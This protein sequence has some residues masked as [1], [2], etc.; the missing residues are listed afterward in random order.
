M[1]GT[2]A[3]ATGPESYQ[4]IEVIPFAGSM[5]AEIQGVDLANLD[6]ATFD[7]LYA[8]WLCHH[9]VVMRDQKITPDQQI[10]F[11][12]RFGDIHHHPYMSGMPDY[13]DIIEIVKEPGDNYT[14]GSSWHTDQMFNPSARESDDAL[15]M[16]YRV[17]AAIP[18]SRICIWPMKHCRM[19]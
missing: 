19:A 17:R 4:Y 13:P 15:C 12:H 16:R 7:E 1:D 8:A 18:Y 6:D 14:F 11:A 2:S 9:V 10:A 3:V 5:G